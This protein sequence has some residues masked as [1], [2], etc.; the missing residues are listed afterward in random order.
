MAAT[1]M[2]AAAKANRVRGK[3]S[4]LYSQTRNEQIKR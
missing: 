1:E 3:R 2:E 4:R